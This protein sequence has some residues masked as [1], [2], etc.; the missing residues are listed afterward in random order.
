MLMFQPLLVLAAGSPRGSFLPFVPVSAPGHPLFYSKPL[1]EAPGP[2]QP[3]G[4]LPGSCMWTLPAL[5]TGLPAPPGLC[6]CKL[7]RAWGALRSP[8]QELGVPCLPGG[9]ESGAPPSSSMR[10]AFPATSHLLRLPVRPEGSWW[11]FPG[12]L[13]RGPG[14]PWEACWGNPYSSGMWSLGTP[15]PL[16]GACGPPIGS[17]RGGC[18]SARRQ[19][20]REHT[21]P[22][23]AV[24][25]SHILSEDIPYLKLLS[26]TFTLTLGPGR[27]CRALVTRPFPLLPG[28]CAGLWVFCVLEPVLWPE[29]LFVPRA[30]STASSMLP[31][32]TDPGSSVRSLRW[33]RR[34]QGGTVWTG[35]VSFW[36]PLEF[37]AFSPSPTGA[38]GLSGGRW[39]VRG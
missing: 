29:L 34:C 31:S 30:L 19:P 25:L 3:R 6:S 33:H 32:G 11:G 36:R 18:S 35:P 23:A 22:E 39:G 8:F 14:G 16:P 24:H 38:D 17:S 28:F 5:P 1:L 9:A 27:A 21:T 37:P 2:L 10:L 7:I 13:P 20:S 4:T 12:F 26:V 15:V